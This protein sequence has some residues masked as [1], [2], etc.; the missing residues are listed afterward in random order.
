MTTIDKSL[1][2]LE[3]WGT[4]GGGV[5]LFL[6]SIF[7]FGSNAWRVFQSSDTAWLVRTGE[8]ILGHGLPA[9]DLFSWTCPG[10]PWVVYQWLFEVGCGLLYQINGFWMVG[11]GAYLLCALVCLWLMP[12][13]MLRAGV[14]SVY[15]FG[16]LSLVFTAVWFWARPQLLS[17]L[18]IPTFVNLLEHFRVHGYSRRLWLLPL[19]MVLWANSHSFWFIGL[20]MILL[21]ILDSL[22]KASREARIRLL[23][24]LVTSALAVMINPYGLKLITYNCSFL[25]EVDPLLW[26]LQPQLMLHPFVN[27]EVIS[28]FVLVWSAT[29]YGRIN[30]PLPGLILAA[31]STVA[32]LCCY[33]FTPV[34]ILLSWP[35][36]GLA[37]AKISFARSDTT[38][39]AESTD[40]ISGLSLVVRKSLSRWLPLVAVIVGLVGFTSEYPLNKPVWFTYANSN[41][42]A[43]EF[44]K[45]HP[46][47]LDRMFCDDGVGCSLI[48]EKL[49]LVFIDNRFDFYGKEFYDDY[50]SCMHA[51]GNWQGYLRNWRVSSICIK[52]VCPLYRELKCSKNW[53]AVYD[54]GVTSVWQRN[55][56]NEAKADG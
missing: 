17:F 52:T 29:L 9:T 33:R 24:V 30:V 2:K 31:L 15:V 39:T 6:F 23:A 46:Q 48:Y 54:D 34:A 14:K 40:R 35:Y 28:Y 4:V 10:R 51:E 25:T 56:G 45:K 8:Y 37:L 42:K 11:L 55:D 50:R 53:N 32:A 26:E 18:L 21:Y 7:S 47:L 22:S 36:A 20:A 38:T 5:A 12:A 27:I 44:L 16:L 43:V 3:T 1:Q 19:L 13:Q 41:Q 49:G